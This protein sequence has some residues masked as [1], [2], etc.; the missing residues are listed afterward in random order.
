MSTSDDEQLNAYLVSYTVTNE[1]DGVI[2]AESAKEAR[3]KF[4]SGEYEASEFEH[5]GRDGRTG[6]VRVRLLDD[7]L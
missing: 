2:Y 7:Y 1:I 4:Q 3:R 5:N 6:G